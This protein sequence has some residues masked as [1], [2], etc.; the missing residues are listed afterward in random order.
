[1]DIL[2]DAV[3]FSNFFEDCS[4][5]TDFELEVAIKVN[6]FDAFTVNKT[7]EFMIALSKLIDGY[8]EAMRAAN[9]VDG[10]DAD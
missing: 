9:P 7:N 5:N 8:N 10:N 6:K 3:L 4:G 1:M 2:K